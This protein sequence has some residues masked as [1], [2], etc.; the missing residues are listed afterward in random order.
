MATPKLGGQASW[1]PYYAGY[2]EAFVR[3]ALKNMAGETTDLHVLDPWNGSGTT[4]SVAFRAG[5]AKVSGFDVNPALV[6]ISR[7]RNLDAAVNESLTPLALDILGHAKR[8]MKSPSSLSSPSR[9]IDGWFDEQ[10][11]AWIRGV[12]RATQ[13]L[14]SK[15]GPTKSGARVAVEDIT[16]LGAFFLV[17]L[18]QVVRAATS[19]LRTSNP[20]W[21]KSTP[22]SPIAADPSQLSKEYLAAVTALAAR[23]QAKGSRANPSVTLDVGSSDRLPLD[24]HSVDLVVTSP[25]YLTRIDYAI[26]TLPELA[27]LEWA[28]DEVAS[29]RKAMLGS[30]LTS[31]VDDTVVSLRS[32]SASRLLGFVKGHKS[33]ASG[34][35]YHRFYQSYFR[36]LEAGLAEVTRVAKPSS[37]MAIVVQDSYYKELRVALPEIVCETASSLG[38]QVDIRESFGSRTRASGHQWRRRYRTRSAATEEAILLRRRT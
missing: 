13:L 30:P 32:A 23:L 3:D 35:Y 16:P 24:A 33:V 11:A 36:Q 28:G 18:F 15:S 31:A 19:S 21:I 29:L 4:T 25:P 22:P 20:T 38:W 27:V 14:L 6:V 8:R 10:T 9:L 34:T 26:A 5:F 1:Y 2:S 17:A 7:A 12:R 37:R